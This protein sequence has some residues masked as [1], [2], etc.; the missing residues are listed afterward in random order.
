LDALSNNQ[1]IEIWDT[2]EKLSSRFK[3]HQIQYTK[4]GSMKK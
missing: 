1:S 2:K 3:L 4:I